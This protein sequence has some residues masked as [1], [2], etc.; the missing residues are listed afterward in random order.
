MNIIEHLWQELWEA[1]V[2]EWG[3]IE[4]D[5][6]RKLYESMPRRVEALLEAKGSHTKY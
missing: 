6:V 4:M 5:F 1:L 2:E 3:N